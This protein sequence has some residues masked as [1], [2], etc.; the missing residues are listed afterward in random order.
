MSCL[1]VLQLIIEKGKHEYPSRWYLVLNRHA[2][3]SPSDYVSNL[4]QWLLPDPLGPGKLWRMPRESLLPCECCT[5]HTVSNKRKGTGVRL[6]T[7][8]VVPSESRR[9]PHSVSQR[10]LLSRGQL[11]SRLLHGDFLPQSRGHLW[12]GSCHYCSFSYWRRR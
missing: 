7:E 10:R 2:Q 9:E 3:G 11:G 5:F 12:T 4:W 6:V 1:W 8:H